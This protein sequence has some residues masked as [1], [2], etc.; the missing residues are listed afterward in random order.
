MMTNRFIGWIKITRPNNVIIAFLSVW[1]A[2]LVAGGIDPVYHLALAAISAA[3][4]TIG[5]NVINDIFDIEIDRINKPERPLPAG[6]VSK[7]EALIIFIVSYLI[8]WLLA[9][10]VSIAMFIMAFISGLILIFYSY[11][12]KR[13]VLAGNFIVSLVSGLAFIYGGM[14]VERVSGTIFPA[15]FAFLYHF[16]REVIKDL[17]DVA[18]DSKKGAD[19]LAVVY[20]T[21]PAL[22]TMSIIF[23]LLILLTIIPYILELYGIIYMLIVV[24]GIYPVLAY[25][26]Y[27]CWKSP[28]PATLGKMSN[29]LKADMLIGLLAIYFG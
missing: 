13:V 12:F 1:V 10:T 28:V 25:V 4:I 8:A 26:I 27:S 29:I 19:T 21:R 9:I 15:L 2:A 3:L 17:Q 5:A 7:S 6:Q 23:G 22:I 11:K 20:G 24:L 16:G 14:A 18:G